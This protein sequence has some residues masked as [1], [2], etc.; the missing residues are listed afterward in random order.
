MSKLIR[1][2]RV[3]DDARIILTLG[4][5]DTP[6]TL[7]LPDD[8]ALLVPLA[9]WRERRA[10]LAGR[11]VGVWL[12]GD[13]DPFELEDELHRLP[14][15]GVHFP[16]FVDGRGYSLAVLLRTRLN[17]GGELRAF[18]DVLQDQF[19]YY[20]RS[21]FDALQPPAGRYTDAQLAAAANAI[22]VF[23]EPYQA[24]AAHPQPLFRRVQRSA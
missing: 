8:G 14:V 15:I 24:S 4:E 3:E 23:S 7:A 5:N 12:A 2:G 17:Y 1:N 22:S 19:N 10:E 20:V 13:E 18:G 9:V 21:G 16:K 6:A 11:D